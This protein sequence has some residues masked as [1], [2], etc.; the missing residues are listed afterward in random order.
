MHIEPVEIYS[1]AS[2]AAVMRHP[3]RRFPGVLV[4]GDTLSSLVGQASSVAERAEGLDEDARDELDGLLEKLR[5]LL[6][7][8]EETLLTHGLDLPYHRSGT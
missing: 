4:Q 3:G 8:Y 6:G 5:D 2:N 7:H 1:D